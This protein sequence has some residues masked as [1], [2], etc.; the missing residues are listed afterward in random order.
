[1]VGQEII[2]FYQYLWYCHTITLLFVFSITSAIMWAMMLSRFIPKLAYLPLLF[3]LELACTAGQLNNWYH[4]Q[5][6]QLCGIGSHAE[7]CPVSWPL[8]LVYWKLYIAKRMPEVRIQTDEKWHLVLISGNDG[9]WW[10]HMPKGKSVILW[11]K[12]ELMIGWIHDFLLLHD[13]YSSSLSQANKSQIK[14]NLLHE[15]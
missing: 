6:S 13:I 4:A 11:H 12:C 3:I 9:R 10:I 8:S 2:L 1:M 15:C 14:M 7:F 5:I